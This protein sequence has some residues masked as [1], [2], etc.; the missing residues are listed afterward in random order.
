M[1]IN[2]TLLSHPCFHVTDVKYLRDRGK[3]DLEILEIWEEKLRSGQGPLV[4]NRPF[5]LKAV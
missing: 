2:A 5:N 3:K 4:H 1:K